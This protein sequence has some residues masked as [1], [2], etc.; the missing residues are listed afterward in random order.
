[1]TNIL[2]YWPDVSPAAFTILREV[3][4]EI[5][6]QVDAGEQVR[7]DVG[8]SRHC[9]AIR[10]MAQIVRATEYRDAVE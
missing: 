10:Y 3:A 4:Q 7:L 6:R 2:R 5:Q 1:M 9:D 8:W